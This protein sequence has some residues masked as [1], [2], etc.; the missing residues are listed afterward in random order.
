MEKINWPYEK[1]GLNF[2]IW[3]WVSDIKDNKIWKLNWIGEK[4]E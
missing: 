3:E 1:T 2:E 4:K